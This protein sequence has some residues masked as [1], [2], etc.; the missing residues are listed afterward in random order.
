MTWHVESFVSTL[1]G[2]SVHTRDAYHRDV[3]QFVEWFARSGDV[4]A[5]DIDR[6][7]LRRY[8]A[9]LTTREFAQP[10]IA[11]KAAALRAY[12]RYL[13][14]TGVLETDPGR[15]LRAPRGAQRLPHVP[16]A[17]QA[18]ALLDDARVRATIGDDPVARAIAQR[19]YAVLELL[20][21]AG[22]RVA[23]ACG[24]RCSDLDADRGYV[25]VLGKGSKVR[26]IPLHAEAFDALRRYVTEARPLLLRDD[27]S[28]EAVFVNARGHALSPRDARRILDRFPLADGRTLHP[29]ALRHAFATHLLEG[30]A[31]LR[32][33]QELLGHTNV[34]TTQR[35]THVTPERLRA[36]H[37]ATHPRG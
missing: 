20:Y 35:Y 11:R 31:D 19:D 26:R 9:Y 23:E 6:L 27:L 37:E 18:S 22:V 33:V 25:T 17:S 14:R 24:L 5:L 21:G 34:A 28:V 16:A 30:G 7:V 4:S 36:V 8:L 13:C 12:T 1:S 2:K 32:V 29:H 3:A 15:A 10:S